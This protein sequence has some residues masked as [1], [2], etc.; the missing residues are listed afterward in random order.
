MIRFGDS[1]SIRSPDSLPCRSAK[2][3]QES[4]RKLTA[5]AD[6]QTEEQ[7]RWQEELEELRKEMDRVR[8]EA[9][10][11][12]LQALKEEMSAVEKQRDVA[13]TRIEE[14]LEEVQTPALG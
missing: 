6:E 11:A 2:E 14:W 10:E 12:Q 13:L 7:R 4:D 5:L 8:K 3:L 1:K 9:E